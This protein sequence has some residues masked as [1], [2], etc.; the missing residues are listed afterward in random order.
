MYTFIELVQDALRIQRSF[1]LY[2]RYCRYGYFMLYRN[3]RRLFLDR[4]II[5]TGLG[6]PIGH[7]R[8]VESFHCCPEP[9]LV[10]NVSKVI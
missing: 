4:E 9:R 7:R 8:E 3:C 5:G 1:V 6:P 2:G 10:Y